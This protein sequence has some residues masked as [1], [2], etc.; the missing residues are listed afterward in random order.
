MI[1][2]ARIA[3]GVA[4]IGI[5]GYVWFPENSTGYWLPIRLVVLLGLIGGLLIGSS[6]SLG[7]VP[8][9]L[10]ATFWLWRRIECADC[11]PGS[12]GPPLWISL[13]LAAGLY[14]FSVAGAA[15]GTFIAER[16]SR[17]DRLER[18]ESK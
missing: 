7:L 12:E 4:V 10:V 16:V 14:A 18:Q 11:P 17:R 13:L 3:I 1:T 9:T 15:A 6:W 5:L 2:L 8:A